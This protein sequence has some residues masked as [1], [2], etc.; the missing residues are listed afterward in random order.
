MQQQSKHTLV[1]SATNSTGQT[2]QFKLSIGPSSDSPGRDLKPM[3]AVS[4]RSLSTNSSPS[5]IVI[6]CRAH[7]PA[8]HLCPSCHQAVEIVDHFLA[9]PHPRWQNIWKELHNLLHQHQIKNSVS[10][11]FHEMF[12]YGL[13]QGCQAPMPISFHHLPT[14]LDAL[15]STQEQ[16]RWWQLYYGCITFS[17]LLEQYHPQLNSNIIWQRLP[18]WFGRPYSRSG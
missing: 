13:Y 10:H 5:R 12:A 6:M 17:K 1:I 3:S 4:Y 14:D 2:I 9:C 7:L 16:I 15:Y 18:R 11:I 8:D